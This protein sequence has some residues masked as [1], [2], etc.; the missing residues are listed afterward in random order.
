MGPLFLLR[1]IDHLS[2]IYWKAV[3]FKSDFLG[4]NPASP[5]TCSGPGLVKPAK[6]L[7]IVKQG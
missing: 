1:S 6:P 2:I 3:I 7:F 5:L 4:L